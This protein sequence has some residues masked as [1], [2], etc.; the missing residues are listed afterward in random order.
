MFLL[1]V[2]LRLAMLFL[3]CDPTRPWIPI[4]P[5]NNCKHPD[6]CHGATAE[7]NYEHIKAS[8]NSP[9]PNTLKVL[10]KTR[11]M[12]TLSNA[13]TLKVISDRSSR[14]IEG[15]TLKV[16]SIRITSVVFN[17]GRSSGLM[18]ACRRCLAP[19]IEVAHSTLHHSTG[20]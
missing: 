5:L 11:T 1:E 15:T 17:V 4:P 6:L 19:R 2:P 13:T 8:S 9:L 10:N 3:L 18:T 20:Q 7:A 16:P 12:L 14:G